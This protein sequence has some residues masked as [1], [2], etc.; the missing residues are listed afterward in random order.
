MNKK[1]AIALTGNIGTGKTYIAK[2]FAEQNFTYV[3]SDKLAHEILENKEEV[4]RFI[5]ERYPQAIN[6]DLINRK[7][8][9]KYLHQNLDNIIEFETR[10]ILSNY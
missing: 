1:I 10:G 5:K 9:S 7:T 6:H 3:D 4:V 8:L 2:L